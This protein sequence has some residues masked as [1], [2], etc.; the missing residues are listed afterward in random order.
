[1]ESLIILNKI[2]VYDIYRVEMKLWDYLFGQ[3]AKKIPLTNIINLIFY[4]ITKIIRNWTTINED[5]Q[6]T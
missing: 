6:L 1:M 2:Y 5:N 3:V 4:H